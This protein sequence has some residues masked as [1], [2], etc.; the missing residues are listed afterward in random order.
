MSQGCSSKITLV[1]VLNYFSFLI[2]ASGK[3][4]GSK[5]KGVGKCSIPRP[6]QT[7]PHPT[8]CPLSVASPPQ[9]PRVNLTPDALRAHDEIMEAVDHMYRGRRLTHIAREKCGI[10][11]HN[12]PG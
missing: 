6:Q 8:P 5:G 7:T 12:Q 11:F 2:L 3:K 9:A 10:V 1:S 4:G